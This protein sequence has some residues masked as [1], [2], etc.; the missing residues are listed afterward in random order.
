[1][2]NW[3][4]GN[5]HM[6]SLWS[7]GTDFPEVIAKYYKD[8]GYQFIAFTEH[9]QFQAGER[10][11]P[12]DAGT[13]E[14]K[15]VIENGSVQAYLNRFGEHWVE[16]R[17][18]D[19]REEVR[20]RPLGEYRGLV[21][22]PEQFLILNGEEVTL[23]HSCEDPDVPTFQ[24]GQPIPVYVN[25]YNTAEP[26][27]PIITPD[28]PSEAMRFLLDSV[29]RNGVD[30][31]RPVITSL[32][33]PNWNWGATAEDILATPGLRFFEIFT[34]LDSCNCYGNGRRASVQR[35]WDI[36]LSLRLGHTGG[37]LL[38]GLAT[39]DSHFYGRM[40]RTPP[41][42]NE[43]GTNPGRAWVMVRAEALTSTHLMQA[44]LRGDYY[45]STGVSLRDIYCD[46]KTLGLRIDPE[47][48]ATYM[49][50]FIGTRRGFSTGSSP[51]VDSAGRAIER[52]TRQ[53]SDQIGVV[54]A[55]VSGAEAHYELSGDELYVRAEVFSDT[56]HPNPSFLP[57]DVKR[58]W[59]QPVLPG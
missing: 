28:T 21:E 53:Y 56:P 37:P 30:P 41:V 27:P 50:R 31:D 19:G 55:E 18:N 22:Q 29:E 2:A 1:M 38:Y 3:Y 42:V 23:R 45:C 20:L 40:D 33:H 15:R 49:T 43:P 25:V 5:L 44:M 11:F 17:H 46:G 59:T 57:T 9:D 12:V 34:A 58:A 4:R 24:E 51:T 7:D 14:G 54:L 16:L 39:D 10:W 48:D 35:M 36:V 26:V 52:T 8:L 32:N 13:E 47:M 6:H